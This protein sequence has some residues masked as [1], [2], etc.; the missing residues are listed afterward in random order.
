MGVMSTI[1]TL[2][3]LLG[4]AKD[5]AEVVVVN[6]TRNAEQEHEEFQAA[7]EQL[8]KEFGHAR[9]G[10]FDSFVDGLNRLPRPALA[11]GTLGL[12]GF[13]M[14]DPVAFSVRMQG[15]ALVPDPLWWLLGAIVSFYFG[16]RELHHF[17]SLN[18]ITDPA[19]VGRV[20]K[21]MHDLDGLRAPVSGN[22]A[23]I[24]DGFDD[25]PAVTEWQ[26]GR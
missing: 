20:I 6:K 10:W 9:Q 25:N 23:Q 16:A 13:A 17:R 22:D 24:S 8:G 7:L 1:L 18:G 2:G 5:L 15:L 19:I 14:H 21:N 12:F 3:G 4:G 26:N 11:L